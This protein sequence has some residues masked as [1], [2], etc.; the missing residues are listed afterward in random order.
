MPR[1]LS[2]NPPQIALDRKEAVS[3]S[4][5]EAASA[6][7]GNEGRLSAPFPHHR[8][9]KNIAA[10]LADGAL[11]SAHLC[12]AE[13]SVKPPQ[14]ASARKE[15]VSGLC[16]EADNACKAAMR[17]FKRTLSTPQDQ[18]Y[19][20]PAARRRVAFRTFV[21]HRIIRQAAYNSTRAERSRFRFA[22]RS[23]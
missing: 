6:Q 5:S 20:C 14:T 16:N 23:R 19:C 18:K 15:A 22:Q 9:Q 21:R 1:I 3:G 8:I 12:G 4:H 2:V 13:S 11:P 10:L 17:A 7:S